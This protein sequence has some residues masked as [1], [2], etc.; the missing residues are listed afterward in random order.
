MDKNAFLPCP[1]HI[2]FNQKSDN[3]SLFLMHVVHAR[4]HLESIGDGQDHGMQGRRM[5]TTLLMCAYRFS[6]KLHHQKLEGTVLL[7]TLGTW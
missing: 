1:I 4:E 5:I 3:I 6:H 2:Y 7:R